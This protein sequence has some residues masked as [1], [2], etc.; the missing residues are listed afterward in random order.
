MKPDRLEQEKPNANQACFIDS[1][2]FLELELDQ[3]HADECEMFLNKVRK[4][5][6]KAVTT[7]FHVDTILV[8]MENYGK[9]PDELRKF[10]SSLLGYKGLKIICPFLTEY[11]LRNIWKNLV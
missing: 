3:K 7:C 6:V 11:A 5:L 4:N 8:V 10:L 9:K 1:N 2:V